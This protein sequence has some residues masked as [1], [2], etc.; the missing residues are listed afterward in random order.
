MLVKPNK[1]GIYH[2]DGMDAHDDLAEPTNAS[3][4][5]WLIL[6]AQGGV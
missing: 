4:Y 1:E 2:I 6:T 5:H 3:I